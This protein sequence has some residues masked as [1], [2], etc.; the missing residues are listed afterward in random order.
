MH[1][2]EGSAKRIASHKLI[3]KFR[4]R[5]SPVKRNGNF[6]NDKKSKTILL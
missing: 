5:F 2:K 1:F 3:G 4:I 6:S